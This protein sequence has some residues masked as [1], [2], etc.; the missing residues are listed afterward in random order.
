M[1]K[2]LEVEN[3]TRLNSICLFIA[4]VIAALSPT[5]ASSE[6][7]AETAHAPCYIKIPAGSELVISI[8]SGRKAE[9]EVRNAADESE[10]T[11]TEYRNGSIRKGSQRETSKLNRDEYN[12]TFKFNRFFDQTPDS[13]IVDEIRIAV[14]KGAVYA[15]LSQTGDHRID[16]YNTGYQRGTTVSPKMSLSVRITGDNQ[17]GGQTSGTLLLETETGDSQEKVPFTA[18][19]GKTLKWD[20]P[21]EK[22][23]NSVEVDI[24]EGQAKITLFQP[25]DY[26]AAI[27]SLKKITPAPK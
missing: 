19:K 25:L 7:G 18:E 12:K 6:D 2:G 10:F 9:L 13:D 8:D 22:G 4:I 24:T 23:V 3:I 1:K 14:N 15:E 20:Y 11:I 26:Q 5:T 17:S 21:A 16:F 27:P